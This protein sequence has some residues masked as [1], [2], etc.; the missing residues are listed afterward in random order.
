MNH[1]ILSVLAAGALM[2][3][4]CTAYLKSAVKPGVKN[5]KVNDGTYEG[6]AAA[7]AV[8]G[9]MKLSVTFQDNK[10]VSIETIHAGSTASIYR[11][12][13]DK[14]F[15]RIIDSQS[16][17][18][19]NITGATESSIAVKYILQ[20]IINE[21]GGNA[22]E[23]RIEIPKSKDIVKKEGYDVIVVG[24]GTS[25]ITSYLSA[26]SNGATVFGMDSAAKIG[27]N[28]AMAVGAMAV[29]PPTQ[30]AL[31]DGTPFINEEELI[32]DWLAYTEGDAKEEM[33]RK[34]VQ[35]SGKTFDW[36]ESN[37]DFH[38]GEKMFGFYH[39]KL[40]PL[41]TTY[42]DKSQTDK[43]TAY[44]NSM[45][46]ATA[47][48]EKNEYMTE[49]TAQELL[50]DNNGKVIGVKAISYDGTT[51]EIYG[52]S[53]I[54]ATG[55]FI[56]NEEMCQKYTGSVWHTYGMTQC[57]GAGIQ[58][59][60]TLGG[61]LMNPDVGV[62][63]HIAQVSN[64]IRS[65]EVSADEKAILTSLLLDTS[66]VMVDSSGNLFNEKAG[67]N[68]A[69][70]AWL[71]GKEFYTIYS[72]EEI[73]KMK[74]SGMSTFNKPT[75]LSQG[76]NYEPNT[77]IPNIESIL[78]IGEKYD[79]V[80]TAES[81]S[82]L[83]DKLGIKLAISDV[84]GKTDGKFYA[85]KGA[86]YAYS[87]SG[88]LDVDTNFNV[89]TADQKPIPNVYAVG[90]DSM[91]VLFASGKACVTYG[92]AAQGYALTSGRLAGYYAAQNTK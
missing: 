86:A 9:E 81:I 41:W 3:S 22:D 77:P 65:D 80:I 26:A 45:N 15:P 55:G 76:D 71:A 8:D 20:N 92:G 50:K 90:N 79:N 25:G 23:W 83:G 30:V 6:K 74:T 1:K 2:L 57:N 72:A 33:I 18:V 39:S 82:E 14:L 21:N 44:I 91:G 47:L 13:E 31:N 70:N 51:Y 66:A 29:N 68:L 87:T 48:N 12:I 89:L 36:L 34:Y 67:K 69:F 54:L 60:Q 42:T 63:T 7:Y 5:A 28:G 64:I 32:Q 27:G 19:D 16:I 53:V 37:F 61:T 24:L 17:H 75:F 49:L 56:G 4:G 10:I 88:G 38:F 40:W 58:M 62:S 43:D 59:A 84:H 85:I 52:K 35:E 73:T 46:Q 11:A 78:A